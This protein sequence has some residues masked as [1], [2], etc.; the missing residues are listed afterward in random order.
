MFFFN[1]ISKSNGINEVFLINVPIKYVAECVCVSRL[2]LPYVL[3][4]IQVKISLFLR[5]GYATASAKSMKIS[6]RK[7]TIEEGKPYV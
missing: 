7:Q 3:V 2:P 4:L 6:R 1:S 5:C